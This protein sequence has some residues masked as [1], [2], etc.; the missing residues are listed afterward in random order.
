MKMK[1][2]KKSSRTRIHNQ[3]KR[4]WKMTLKMMFPRIKLKV[5]LKG[6]ASNK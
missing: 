2:M 6:E 1:M 3:R 4:T 5:K